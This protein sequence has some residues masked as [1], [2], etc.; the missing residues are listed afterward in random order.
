MHTPEH[1]RQQL[2]ETV[3]SKKTV[4]EGKV[5]DIDHWTV[6]M[7]DNRTS[8]REIIR[9]PGAAAVVPVDDGGNVILVHQFRHAIGRVTLEIPAG[10]LEPDEDPYVCA[11]RE[12]EEETA[13]KTGKLVLLNAMASSPGIFSEVIHIY[14]ATELS[15]GRFHFDRDEFI[16]VRTI[17]MDDAIDM[18]MTGQIQDAKTIVGLFAAREYLRKNGE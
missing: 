4:F 5:V 7:P 13:K 2:N 16:H 11:A 18:V 8:L 3:E 6:K 15:E 1:V 14:L 17:A 10:R 9:H 12:L